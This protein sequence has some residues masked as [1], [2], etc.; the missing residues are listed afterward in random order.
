MTREHYEKYARLAECV[1]DEVVDNLYDDPN[2]PHLP[3]HNIWNLQWLH[4]TDEHLNNI[5]LK[6]FDAKFPVV[7]KLIRTAKLTPHG[8]LSLA[9]NVCILKHILV[10]RILGVEPPPYEDNN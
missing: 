9:N 10:F 3:M 6:R 4:A 5:P 1:P 7:Q 2:C 8:G